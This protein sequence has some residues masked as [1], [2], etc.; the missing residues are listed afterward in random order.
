MM[1]H[2]FVN[3]RNLLNAV[4]G[5]NYVLHVARAMMCTVWFGLSLG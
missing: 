4:D 1:L 3:V 2:I 5:R